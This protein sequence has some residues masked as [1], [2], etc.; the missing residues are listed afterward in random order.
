VRKG[1]AD[2]SNVTVVPSGGFII[3]QQTFGAYF[4]KGSNKEQKIDPSNDV[5]IFARHIAPAL[6][7]TKRFVGEEPLDYI[8]RQYN[9]TMA[10]ILPRHGIELEIIPRKESDGEVISAS[11]VRKLLETK[12]FDAIATLVPETTLEYLKTLPG[13]G[14]TLI[15]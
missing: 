2:L 4:E 1:V 10:R 12:D 8:T 13:C 5:E 3:S 9:D 15:H 14:E 6:G 11:R 7:I